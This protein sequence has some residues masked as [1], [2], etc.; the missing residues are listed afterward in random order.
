MDAAFRSFD[1]SGFDLVLSSNHACAKN[2]RTPPGALHVCYCHTPMRYA[3]DPGFLAGEDLGRGGRLA[4]RALLPWLRRRDRAAAAGPH[5]YLANSTVVAERIRRFYGRDATVLAPPVDVEPLLRT[6]RAD[7]GYYLF[8]SRIVPYKRADLAVAACARLGRAIKVAGEGRA[9]PRL[10]AAAGPD[11]EFLGHVPAGDLAGLI[12]GAR[13]LLFPGEEDFGIVPVEAQAAGVP[14]IAFGRGGARD[15]VV[16][17]VTGLLFEP[18]TPEA[19][20][21]AIADFEDRSWDEA[22]IRAN[23]RRFARE[24]FLDGLA[25]AVLDASVGRPP[26]RYSA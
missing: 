18:Q 1:L 20:A 2:V 24:R 15:T 6:A 17:G 22:A 26:D 12:A 8:L 3:W 7:G 10:R 25:R 5:R 23:A 11:A 14:V 4:A 9:L 13:A 19:L 16:D 21:A